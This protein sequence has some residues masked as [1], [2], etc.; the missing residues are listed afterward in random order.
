VFIVEYDNNDL[1]SGIPSIEK[2]LSMYLLH[3]KPENGSFVM[4]GMNNMFI[5]LLEPKM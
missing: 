3:S 1:E 5:M 2:S 4:L